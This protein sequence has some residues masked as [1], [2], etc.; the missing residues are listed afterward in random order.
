MILVD[1]MLAESIT[2]HISLPSVVLHDPS[3]RHPLADEIH[4]VFLVFDSFVF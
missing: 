3:L 4:K 1:S 2:F